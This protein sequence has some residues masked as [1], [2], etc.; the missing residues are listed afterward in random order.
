MK[1]GGWILQKSLALLGLKTINLALTYTKNVRA[2]WLNNKNFTE[3]ERKMFL[4]FFF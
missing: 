1:G 4:I 3:K 2:P